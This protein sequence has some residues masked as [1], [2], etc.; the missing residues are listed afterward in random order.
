MLKIPSYLRTKKD[1]ETLVR[2]VEELDLLAGHELKMGE[3]DYKDLVKVL[4]FKSYGANAK[5]A[6][7]DQKI[8]EYAIILSGLVTVT[9]KN[10]DILQWKWALNTLNMLFEWKSSVLDKKVQ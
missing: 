8:D 6:G 9:V 4:T 3:N 5:I 7:I 10:P 1:K 2:F